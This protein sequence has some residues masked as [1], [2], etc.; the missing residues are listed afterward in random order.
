MIMKKNAYSRMVRWTLMTGIA[1]LFMVPVC[2][3]GQTGK[4]IPAIRTITPVTELDA[5]R[6]N[7]R[8]ENA[9]DVVGRL[10]L[11]KSNQVVIGNRKLTVKPGLNLSG[12]GKYNLVGANLDQDGNVVALKKISDEPN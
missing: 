11:I 6:T 9:F 4:A 8:A 7:I 2:L 3:A 5:S 1:G 10:N 12:I